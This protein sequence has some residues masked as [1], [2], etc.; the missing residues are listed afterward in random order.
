M[1]RLSV[2]ELVGRRVLL[3]DLPW[4]PWQD[5][6]EQTP[7]D[8]PEPNASPPLSASNNVSVFT[9]LGVPYAEPPIGER[10]FKVS[11]RER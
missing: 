7:P 11:D 5:P 1:V 6:L 4:T 9:F 10:R 8:R 2:G 3:P